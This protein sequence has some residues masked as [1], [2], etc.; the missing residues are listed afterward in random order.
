M[1]AAARL[2]HSKAV[3]ELTTVSQCS[4]YSKKVA[5]LQLVTCSLNRLLSEALTSQKLWR[6]DYEQTQTPGAALAFHVQALPH[7]HLNRFGL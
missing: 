6:P 4:S 1:Y 5:C 7:A 3:Q 2:K